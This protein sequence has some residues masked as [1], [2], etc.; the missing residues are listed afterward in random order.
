MQ[1]EREH[2]WEQYSDKENLNKMRNKKNESKQ[3]STIRYDELRWNALCVKH[4]KHHSYLLPVVIKLN[5]LKSWAAGVTTTTA[6]Q[7]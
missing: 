7:H 6:M 2:K 3:E 1:R 4:F 5:F